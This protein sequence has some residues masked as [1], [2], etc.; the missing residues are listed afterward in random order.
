MSRWA[1]LVVFLFAWTLTTHGKVSVSGDEPH[2]LMITQSL[3]YDGDLDLQNNF[4][5]KEYQ[6]YYPGTL[7]NV[8]LQRRGARGEAYS[9]H[10]PG[11][12]AC[13][14][15]APPWYGKPAHPSRSRSASGRNTL[16]VRLTT[17]DGRHDG[18]RT[19]VP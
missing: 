8:D 17:G 18:M 13:R 1:A 14:Q 12:A 6:A 7:R 4:D 15:K 16:G 19:P 9:I 11:T 2:Y 10:A 3:L 5:R